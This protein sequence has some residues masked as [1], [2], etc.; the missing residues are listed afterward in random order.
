M[1][2]RTA[3]ARH[4]DTARMQME[5]ARDLVPGQE[6]CVAP[7]FAIAEDRAIDVGELQA[8]LM[9]AAGEEANLDEG[10]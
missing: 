4:L 8:D 1:Q 2:D 3:R 7:V 5:P 10:S 9:F 6:C